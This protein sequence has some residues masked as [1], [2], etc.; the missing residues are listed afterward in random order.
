MTKHITYPKFSYRSQVDLEI[1]QIYVYWFS[2]FHAKPI[3]KSMVFLNKSSSVFH[4]ES[5]KIEFAFF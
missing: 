5:N 3:K 1:Q 2:I 4:K